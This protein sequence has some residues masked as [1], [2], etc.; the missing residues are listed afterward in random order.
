MLQ[1]PPGPMGVPG[2]P[3][4]AG[5]VIWGMLLILAWSSHRASQGRRSK[6][7]VWA[8]AIGL[9]RDVLLFSAPLYDHLARTGGPS[10][11]AMPLFEGWLAQV[12]ALTLTA[13]FLRHLSKQAEPAGRYLRIGLP[14]ITFAWLAAIVAR[15]D[16]G[17]PPRFPPAPGMMVP[18][19]VIGLCVLSFGLYLTWRYTNGSARTVM[20]FGIAIF[21][22]R[23]LA[24]IGQLLTEAPPHGGPP[25]L[26]FVTTA[27]QVGAT[28]F[29]YLF[30]RQNSSEMRASVVGLEQRV[31]ERTVELSEANRRLMEQSTVDP[32]TMLRNRRFFDEA[33]SAEWARSLRNGSSLAIA[34]VD[35]D[36]FKG[37]NDAY[38][39]QVGDACLVRVAEA[40][41]AAARRPSDVVTRY[42]GDE[43]VLLLPEVDAAGAE[44]VLENVRAKVERLRL[45]DDASLSVTISAGVAAIVPRASESPQELIRRADRALYEAKSSGRNRVG[46]DAV[47]A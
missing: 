15:P 2:A 45:D 4:I 13:A 32:L 27:S 44:R 14:I 46:R 23:D 30:V 42:G 31:Q 35:V 43:F 24:K 38:G 39:H 37:I 33:L 29:G 9:L 17:P 36:K 18:V 47:L 1:P 41:A 40:L 28:V 25:D 16:G 10:I 7:V 8:F 22:V 26:L 11:L 21:V 5:I 20:L 6:L 34:V 12:A 19:T 3:H